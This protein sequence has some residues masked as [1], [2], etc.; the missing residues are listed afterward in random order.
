MKNRNFKIFILYDEGL[1][2][3]SRNMLPKLRYNVK[4]CVAVY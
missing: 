4:F 1:K 2:K 3:I